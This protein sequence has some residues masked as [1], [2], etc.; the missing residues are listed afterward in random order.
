MTNEQKLRLV[1]Q[2]ELKSKN[3]YKGSYNRLYD[4]CEKEYQAAVNSGRT[5]EEALKIAKATINE[6]VKGQFKWRTIS[7][8][9]FSFLTSAIVLFF[10]LIFAIC[11]LTM[12]NVM[13][14]FEVLFPIYF[15]AAVFIL[16]YY[17]MTLKKRCLLDMFVTFLLF[18]SLIAMFSQLWGYV[19]WGNHLLDGT[20]N[21]YCAMQ[22]IFP[23]LSIFNQY[24]L[25]GTTEKFPLVYELIGTYYHFDPTILVSLGCLISSIVFIYKERRKKC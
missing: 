17:L 11:G 24:R 7:R 12:P 4:A 16:I 14:L 20:V 15:L 25:E 8:Y 22:Y 5:E 6:K 18:V 23:G 9:R 13:G 19:F 2:K 10:S 3:V 1:V 21:S